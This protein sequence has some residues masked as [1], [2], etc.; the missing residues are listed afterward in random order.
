MLEQE[1]E[2]EILVTPDVTGLSFEEIR[3]WRWTQFIHPDDLDETVRRWQECVESGKPWYCEHRFRR[4]DGV[5]CWH[6]SRAIPVRNT[7]GDITMWIGSNTDIT[8]QK[9]LA[10]QKEAFLH[11]ATH[12]LKMPLTALQGNLQLAQRRVLQGQK[13]LGPEQT[14]LAKVLGE[15]SLLLSRAF[16]QVRLQTR[17][18][19]DL[20]DVSHLQEHHLDVVLA[21]CDLISLVRE[22]VL[23]TQRAYQERVIT[24]KLPEQEELLVLA[25][26]DRIGQVIHNY[27]SNALKYSSN[28]KP[29]QVGLACEHATAS[30][31]VKDQGPGLSQEMQQHIWEQFYRVPGIEVYTGESV[32]LGVGLTTCQGIIHKHQGQVGVESVPGQGSRFWFTLPLLQEES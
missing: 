24:V 8:E 6:V 16:D 9:D 13:M 30:V 3:G 18:V 1:Q 28:D 27:L 7:Q 4:A 14:D 31:W 15:M 17:L 10:R 21:P 2:K 26:H 11:M 25:D 12:E 20:L 22:V 29:V 23:E 32:N 5:Y 19:N